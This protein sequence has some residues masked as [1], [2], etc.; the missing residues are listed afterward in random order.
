MRRLFMISVLC[1]A[2][3][4]CLPLSTWAN[5]PSRCIEMNRYTAASITF[6]NKS[7]YTMTLK[8][9]GV[10]GGLYS[11]VSLP[12]HS[13]QVVHFNH[14]QTFKLKIKATYLGHTSYHDGVSF[15]VTCTDTEWTEGEM[16]FQMST[17]GSGLGPTIS[18]KEFESNE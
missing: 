15:S 3:P 4:M 18:A 16:S 11:T 14:S 10:Y 5:H 13:S 12:A 2:L 1:I 6:T 17:Y 9:I 7:A 8:I